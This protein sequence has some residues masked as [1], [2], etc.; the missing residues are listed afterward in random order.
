M[1]LIE[2]HYKS[3]LGRIAFPVEKMIRIL[4]LQHWFSLSDP[5]VED[6]LYDSNSMC[7]FS[8]IDLG[9]EKIPDETTI[10]RFRHLL[11][12]HNLG[13]QIFDLFKESLDKRG[14]VLSKGTIVDATIIAAPSSTKNKEHKRDKEMRSTKKGNQ[15][16]F[17]MKLHIGV[18]AKEKIIHSIE[19][20][21]ANVHDSQ[22]IDKLLHG[23][24]REVY[25]DSAYTG[26]RNKIKKKAP[27]AIDCT[28]KKNFR[29]RGLTEE[30]ST[31]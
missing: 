28:H 1:Q 31:K 12:E 13:K 20:T 24:E 9:C 16:Y 29:Y 18:D 25:G 21:S 17:G 11:E 26:Q 6:A 23:E 7:S 19:T 4:F 27:D 14:I 22:V 10:L 30:D 2:P 8:K 3:P 5:S 15:Y